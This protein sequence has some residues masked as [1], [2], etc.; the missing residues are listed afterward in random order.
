MT[1]AENVRVVRERIAAACTRA[2]RDPS[3]V[4]LVGASKGV[5]PEVIGEAVAAGVADIGENRGQEL[6]DKAAALPDGVRWHFIGSVQT[7]KV[8]YLDPVVLVHSIDRLTEAE[9]LQARGE[10]IG[11]TWDVLV[12][13]NVGGEA[14]KQGVAPEELERFVQG[15]AAYPLVRPRGLMFLAPMAVMQEDVRWVFARG[16]NLLER[17]RHVA[18]GLEEL[19][20]GMSQ[21]YEVA[22][23]EGA[24][25]VRVGGAI[26]RASREE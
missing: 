21:D 2:G 17:C 11:R 19:S 3:E 4:T 15:L 6:R 26:F 18:G 8:R 20:M 25:I 10:R 13:C 1:I 7:N 23:E 22:V 5:P 16:R 14:A 12:E 9:A 24:T